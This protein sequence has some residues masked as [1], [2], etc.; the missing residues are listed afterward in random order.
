MNT[1]LA[2]AQA[3]SKNDQKQVTAWAGIRNE[4]A[5]GN[6]SNYTDGEVKLMLAGIRDFISRNPA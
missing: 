3:Y 4:A 6:Y 1:E 5:H 2:K